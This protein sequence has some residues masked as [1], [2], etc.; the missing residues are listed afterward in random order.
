[1]ATKDGDPKVQ[2]NVALCNYLNGQLHDPLGFLRALD[3]IRSKSEDS[4]ADS[5]E[6]LPRASRAS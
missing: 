5:D 1:M 3:K 2:M 6:V 4:S